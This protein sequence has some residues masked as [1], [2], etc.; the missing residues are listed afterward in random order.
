MMVD[1]A[2]RASLAE[3]E[4]FSHE[5]ETLIAPI[6]SS[7]QTGSG[8]VSMPSG[9]L[10]AER[11]EI[12]GLIGVGG[13]GTVYRARDREL[14]ELVALKMLRKDLVSTPGMLDRF[15]RE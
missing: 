11:Y 14:E 4:A 13:M 9:P 5:G 10:L 12:L 6:G 15:R 1:P 2:A 8:V 3:N 7:L